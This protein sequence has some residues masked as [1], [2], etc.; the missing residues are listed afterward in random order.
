L[1]QLVTNR[2]RPDIARLKTDQFRDV[3]EYSRRF[4]DKLCAA[5]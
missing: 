2:P 3:V 4:K 1:F 5:R